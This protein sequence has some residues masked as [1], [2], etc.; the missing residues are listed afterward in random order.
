MRKTISLMMVLMFAFT[1]IAFANE[2]EIDSVGPQA[3]LYENTTVG[4]SDGHF[5]SSEFGTPSS[6]SND[7]NVYF[8]NKGTSSV[9]V[10]L[11]KKGLFGWSK[12]DSFNAAAGT[13]PFKRMTGASKTTY[14]IKVD[15]ST[16]AAIK[17][18]LRANQL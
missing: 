12:V 10:T 13:N 18:H 5:V 14:R 11:E 9:T 8:D 16:G 2:G 7:I 4:A 3:L 15:S 17:G 1:S 6:N